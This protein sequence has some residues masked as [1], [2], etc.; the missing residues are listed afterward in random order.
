ME[1]KKYYPRMAPRCKVLHKNM[2]KLFEF[3]T[4]EAEKYGD[5]DPDPDLPEFTLW[6]WDNE[7][8]V[9]VHVSVLIDREELF[10]EF[11]KMRGD[12]F[13]FRQ[14]YQ[15]IV[16]AGVR[17]G[18]FDCQPEKYR[19]VK[20]PPDDDTGDLSDSVFKIV[21]DMCESTNVETRVSGGKALIALY[22][23]NSDAI[24]YLNQ[25]KRTEKVL[26]SLLRPV[27]KEIR[28]SDVECLTIGL[29]ILENTRFLEL[30]KHLSWLANTKEVMWAEARR[31]LI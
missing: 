18:T 25:N 4:S 22:S 7:F 20:S 14:F 2:N 24:D 19:L 30:T 12:N 11:L 8:L 21:F 6:K 5:I 16:S 23:N 31:R 10:V 1:M 9:Q 13:V 27:P 15:N 26:S 17:N 28:V 29:I 3:L